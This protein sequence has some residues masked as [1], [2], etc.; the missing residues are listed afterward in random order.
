MAGTRTAYNAK[1][2]VITIDGTYIT[3]VGEDMVTGE[4]DEEFF[5]TV[6]GAQGDVAVNEINNPLGTI[7]LTLQGTS[8]QNAMLLNYARTNKEFAI[9]IN[10]KSLGEK[11]GGTQARIKNFP[12]MENGAELADREYEIGVFDFDV[13]PE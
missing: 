1:D 10:N 7:T 2:C 5:S 9:W 12:S 3:G 8:P 13:I 11:F 6:V 4:K